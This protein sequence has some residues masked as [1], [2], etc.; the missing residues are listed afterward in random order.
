[1]NMKRTDLGFSLVELL[2]VLAIFLIITSVVLFNQ[3]KSSSDISLSNVTYEIALKIRQT[4]TYGLLVKGTANDYDNA[5]GVN[6]YV[7]IADGNKTK[8]RVFADNTLGAADELLVYD[9]ADTVLSEHSLTEGNV[10]SD[11]C[12]YPSIGDLA[13]RKCFST[14]AINVADISFQRPE[15]AAIISDPSSASQKGEI[16]ITVKSALGDKT[17]TIKVFGSGQISVYSN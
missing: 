15:S 5:Y 10:I 9:A 6:F 14:S 12:T 11:V 2:V 17:R 7:D 8:F 13:N 16:D 1:M 4:Q 3:D